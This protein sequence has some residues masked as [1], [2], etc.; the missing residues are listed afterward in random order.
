MPRPR[1]TSFIVLTGA[2]FAGVSASAA[3]ALPDAASAEPGM[4]VGT[5]V[6]MRVGT[7]VAMVVA[8]GGFA[9]AIV[10]CEAVAGSC[11][12]ADAIGVTLGIADGG[13]VAADAGAAAPTQA[14][15]RAGSAATGSGVRPAA[16]TFTTATSAFLL[17]ARMSVR[18]NTSPVWSAAPKNAPAGFSNTCRLVTR[19]PSA[20]SAQAVANHP[21]S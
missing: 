12:A 2:C 18:G 7:P 20:V 15:T 21:I 10:F 17:T 14:P 3:A 16:A 8:T 1:I 9:G 13:T 19:T 5:P 4:G 11:V 6:A